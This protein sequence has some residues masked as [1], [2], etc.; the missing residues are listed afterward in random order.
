MMEDEYT[1]VFLCRHGFTP[2]N[3]AGYNDQKNIREDICGYDEYMPLETQFGTLQAK[4][5]GNFLKQ[6][7]GNS[8]KVLVLISPYYRTRQ[9]ASIALKQIPEEQKDDYTVGTVDV[10]REINQ[11]LQYAEP[12]TKDLSTSIGIDSYS[13]DQT[14][15]CHKEKFQTHHSK[16]QDNSE[17]NNTTYDSEY[18]PYNAGESLSDVKS[19]LR[20][21]SKR[22]K[23]DIDSKKYDAIVIVSHNTVLKALYEQVTG[24]P[25]NTKI[26]TGGA[27]QLN[28][29]NPL[30]KDDIEAQK[31]VFTPSTS[32]PKD[33]IIN[34]EKYNNHKKIY[35]LQLQIDSWKRNSVFRDFSGI[36]KNY[37]MPLERECEFVQSS[38]ETI[39]N[40][41]RNNKDISMSYIEAPIGKDNITKDTVGISRFFILSGQATFYLKENEKEEFRKI[42]IKAG[43]NIKIKPNTIFYYENTGKLPLQ[44]LKKSNSKPENIVDYG[45]T[46]MCIHNARK[47]LDA[48][49][50]DDWE[51]QCKK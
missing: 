10:L 16:K 2:A 1:K 29:C 44:L 32:V 46:P 22:L 48:R 43:E 25:L 40:L 45:L 15:K 6:S 19:R 49:D 35:N 26:Y 9:T 36:T 34:P 12:K 24:Q 27:I 39:V 8:K 41:P 11:G 42:Q 3:N 5:L 37:M 47:N 18:I 30:S 13:V 23:D 17:Y 7:L 28:A 21:F 50:K 38:G 31:C 33:Y 4:E 14:K 20:R 51:R